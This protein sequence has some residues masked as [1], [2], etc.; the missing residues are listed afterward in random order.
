MSKDRLFPTDCYSGDRIKPKYPQYTEG[1]YMNC[2]GIVRQ[3][4]EF[5]SFRA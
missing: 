5:V 3:F 2:L 1:I 4:I